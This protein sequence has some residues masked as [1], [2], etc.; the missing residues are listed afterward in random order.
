MEVVLD[1]YGTQPSEE[2]P[3]RELQIKEIPDKLKKA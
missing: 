3:L 1:L 2:E